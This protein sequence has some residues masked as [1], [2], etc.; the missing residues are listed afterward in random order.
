VRVCKGVC[1]CV[2][3]CTC[4]CLCVHCLIYVILIDTLASMPLLVTRER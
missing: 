3:V 1:V 4:V 2:C